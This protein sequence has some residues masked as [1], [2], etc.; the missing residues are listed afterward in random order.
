ML[1]L[2]N[3][4]AL[5][6][7]TVLKCF[8]SSRI[9]E[10]L[11]LALKFLSVLDI[12]FTFRIFEQFVP[13][14]KNRVCPDIFYCIE[15]FFIFQD[16]WAICACPKNRMCTEFTVLKIHFLS[17]RIFSKLGLAWK[18]ERALNSLYSIYIF[19]HWKFWTTCDGPG[20]QSLPWIFYCNQIFFILQDIWATCACPENR[21]CP[22]FFQARGGRPP[23]PALYATGYEWSIMKRSVLNGHRKSYAFKETHNGKRNV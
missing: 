11:A 4:V 7:F 18:T 12:I 10:Q 13:A 14:L 21:V 1:A 5:N 9:F 23:P 8:L 20:T 2:K 17:L 16:F 15:I 19:Y 6:S 3:R 22:D